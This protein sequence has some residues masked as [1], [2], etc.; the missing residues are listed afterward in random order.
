MEHV[1]RSHREFTLEL[2]EWCTPHP[3]TK[4]FHIFLYLP[5]AIFVQ[6]RELN[7]LDEVRLNLVFLFT[8]KVAWNCFI[9]VEYNHHFTQRLKSN[10]LW[11]SRC[12]RNQIC[13]FLSLSLS[14][15][16]LQRSWKVAYRYAYK[17][18]KVKRNTKQEFISR[19]A[20]STQCRP[21]TGDKQRHKN[22]SKSNNRYSQISYSCLT[23][24]S[25]VLSEKPPDIQKE[26]HFFRFPD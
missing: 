24:C 9:T 22:A 5:Y 7:I 11:I 14:L 16:R 13:F 12:Q 6:E 18:L 8:V 25:R 3:G 17:A 4:C 10:K 26:S 19:T 21:E 23:P 1:W 15:L 2:V 20:A